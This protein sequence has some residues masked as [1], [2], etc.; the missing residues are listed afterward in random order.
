M[1]SSPLPQDWSDEELARWGG[2]AL[3]EL[4]DA[5]EWLVETAVAL[6]R[7]PAP[8]VAQRIWA[9]GL[10]FD[11]WSQRPALALRSAHE[12]DRHLLF[13]AD[14]RDIDLRISPG[15][16]PLYDLQ[17]QV[18]GPGDAG[19]VQLAATDGQG[20]THRCVLD[21]LGGFE[22]LGLPA[23]RYRLSI[24]LDADTLELPDL[25]IGDARPG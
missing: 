22:L 18:L 4:Q 6:W 21:D 17:G 13:S 2:R 8:T 7:A 24:Q 5:P 25:D 16:P 11:S 19:T 23:G 3:R 20:E 15:T 1:T 12:A 14:G 10:R 9:A